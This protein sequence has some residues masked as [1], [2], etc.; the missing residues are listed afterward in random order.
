MPKDFK[1]K[2]NFEVA[3]LAVL[4][5]IS[6]DLQMDEHAKLTLNEMTHECAV[7]ICGA[8]GKLM[9][10]SEA[11][12][13]DSRAIQE[14]TKLILSDEMQNATITA[15]NKAVTKYTSS[16]NGTKANPV[17]KS[18]RAGLLYPVSRCRHILKECVAGA[19]KRIGDAAPV[20][21]AATLQF[22]MSD[23]LELAANNVQ[24]TKRIRMGRKDLVAAVKQDE[25]LNELFS[26]VF[27]VYSL[28]DIHVSFLPKPK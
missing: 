26:G 3:N 14:A 23:V 21:L 24:D 9:K 20:Y 8:I 7:K 11:I 6:P 13:I 1:Q 2:Y 16:D 12:T 28:P 17:T 15:A 18:S 4:R 27:S 25:G 22:I 19:N 5:S 10:D